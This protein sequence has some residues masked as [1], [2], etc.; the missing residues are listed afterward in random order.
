LA[1]E[2]KQW[3]TDLDADKFA[4]RTEATKKLIEAGVPAIEA[5]TEAAQQSKSAEVTD[6]ALEILTEL[7]KSDN[8]A[9]RE[10]AKQALA[11][12]AQGGDT[13]LAKNATQIIAPPPEPAPNLPRG[14]RRGLIQGNGGNIQI[15]SGGNIQINGQALPVG[16]IAMRQIR[17]VNGV[18]NIEANDDGRKVKIVDDPAKG[19]TVEVTETVEGKEQTKKYE[20]K[21]AEELKK[22]HPE[23]DALFQKY[24]VQ[25]AGPMRIQVGAIPGVPGLQIQAADP[26]LKDKIEAVRKRLQALTEQLD[27]RAADTPNDEQT[28][29]LSDELKEIERLLG[30]GTEAEKQ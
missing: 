26:Q 16:K 7:F 24:A 8:T 28:K 17:I 4:I 13:N 15:L 10:A 23:A 27:K 5:V 18:R 21:N 30:E 2:I 20:A 14:I 11:K 22:N 19:I 29:K 12:L 9:T 6:R 1:A 25:N 3:I